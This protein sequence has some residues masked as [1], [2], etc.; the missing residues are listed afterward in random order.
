MIPVIFGLLF[1]MVLGAAMAIFLARRAPVGYE[2]EQGFHY[3]PE[4]PENAQDFPG[5]V[6]VMVR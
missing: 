3:G 2:D 1:L 4:Q 5:A 6:G